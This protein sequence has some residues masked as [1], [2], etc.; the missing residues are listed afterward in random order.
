MARL[1]Q[2]CVGVVAAGLLSAAAQD[3]QDYPSYAPRCL[4]DELR[5]GAPPPDPCRQ[6]FAAFGLTGPTPIDDNGRELEATGSIL[7]RDEV[8]DTEGA[9]S[10]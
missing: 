10:K 2:A 4:T 7:P 9:R 8:H 5:I 6:Q 3:V 1:F